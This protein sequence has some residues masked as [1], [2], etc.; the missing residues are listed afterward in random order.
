MPMSKESGK[1]LAEKIAK[2]KSIIREALDRYD[3]KM[4]LAWTGGGGRTLPRRCIY[5]EKSAMAR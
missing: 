1:N 5:C 2:S 4:A 3:N